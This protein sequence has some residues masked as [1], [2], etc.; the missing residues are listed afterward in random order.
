[1]KKDGEMGTVGDKINAANASWTFSGIADS[2]EEHV[3]KS[4]PFYEE[5]HE[6]VVNLSDYFVN[7][8]SV[9]YELGTST[10]ILLHK[11]ATRAGESKGKFIGIDSVP[12][13]IELANKKYKKNNIEYLNEDILEYDF[14]SSD[15][16]VSYYLLQ[17]IRPSQRQ[18]LVN[19]IY[20]AL[21]WGGAFICFEKVRAVD[22]RFQDIATTLY[23]DYKLNQGYS[24]EE[25]M[26]KTRSLKGVME[27]FSTQANIDIFKRAG[28]VDI[29][30]VFKYVCFEGFLV[31]K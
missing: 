16:I 20:N 19:K 9:V 7:K 11:I 14:Q 3:S 30:V 1:V 12:E 8:D 4:V 2:F 10:G 5:G 15:L 23:S 28:F 25:I 31:I 27:P 6:L 17:F 13:M 18:S 24:S 22:A 21:N 29:M 26:A